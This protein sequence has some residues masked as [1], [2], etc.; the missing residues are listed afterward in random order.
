MANILQMDMASVKAFLRPTERIKTDTDVTISHIW[1]IACL[2]LFG[3]LC[4]MKTSGLLKA[5]LFTFLLVWVANGNAS[6]NPDGCS[7]HQPAESNT[8]I[9]AANMHFA[10]LDVLKW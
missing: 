8:G 5:L 6:L 10:P 2:H 4:S 7:Y 9:N 1:V 3:L